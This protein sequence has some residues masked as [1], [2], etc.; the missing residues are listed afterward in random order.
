MRPFHK[1][2]LSI[3]VLLI[4]VAFA[5]YY[6]LQNAG[7]FK[8]LNIQKPWLIV[9]LVLLFVLGYI[10]VSVITYFLLLPLG[11]RLDK[12][13]SFKLSI[14]TGFYN[15]ITP[16]RG[17]MAARALYLKRN[18]GFSYLKFLASLTAS[19]VII[20]FTASL[21]GIISMIVIYFTSQVFSWIIFL[22]FLAFFL[23]LLTI[24]TF[25]PQIPET[26]YRFINHFIKVLNGWELIRHNSRV[27][28]IVSAMSLFQLLISALNLWLQF[29][30]FGV[31]LTL[32]ASLF[33]A[34]IGSLGLL[35]SI[36]PAGLGVN[37]AILVFSAATI[38]ITTA[39]SLAAAILGRVISFI[40]L[41]VLGPIFSWQLVNRNKIR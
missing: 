9:P 26:R 29:S 19:L 4:L 41:F 34:A 21:V 13:E 22:I 8:N 3:T 10:P 7:Q 12:V 35:I 6:L 33:L 38:G 1:K 23:S 5:G 31:G 37:E 39:E 28:F 27:I 14:V 30:L 36:T 2:I 16:F 40:V 25:S 17:G 24:I 18:Y 32:G 15:V 20:F 11:A